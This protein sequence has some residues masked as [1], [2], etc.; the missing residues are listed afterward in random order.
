MRDRVLGPNGFEPFPE[1]LEKQAI[2]HGVKNAPADTGVQDPVIHSSAEAKKEL[3][4]KMNEDAK[5]QAEMDRIIKERAA[6]KAR[7]E[8]EYLK[9]KAE[10]AKAVKKS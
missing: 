5:K 9:A 8:E 4:L 2:K 1:R 7:E 3:L 10:E 6:A